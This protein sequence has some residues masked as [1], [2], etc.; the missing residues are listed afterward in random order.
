MVNRVSD[1][2]NH[3]HQRENVRRE[4]KK[5]DSMPEKQLQK[6]TKTV[7]LWQI[8]AYEDWLAS[9]NC[10]FFGIDFAYLKAKL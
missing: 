3:D 5:S 9:Q 6:Q 7:Y 8:N 4:I 10:I 2:S 1:I